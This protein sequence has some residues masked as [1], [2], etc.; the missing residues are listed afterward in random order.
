MVSLRVEG[1][2]GKAMGKK[3]S[4]NFKPKSLALRACPTEPFHRIDSG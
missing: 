2:F 4:A 3:D 1:S